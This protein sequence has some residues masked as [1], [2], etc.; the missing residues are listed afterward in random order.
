MLY[1]ASSM[2][3]TDRGAPNLMLVFPDAEAHES[4]YF[5]LRKCETKSQQKKTFKIQRDDLQIDAHGGIEKET[6][7]RDKCG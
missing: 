5:D 3:M 2:I 1:A 7:Y 6:L 4:R